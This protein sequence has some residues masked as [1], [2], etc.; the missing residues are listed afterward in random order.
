MTRLERFLEQD[1]VRYVKRDGGESLKL[2]IAGQ[3]GFPD[4]TL[5]LPGARAIF[6]ETKTLV[7]K[8]RPQQRHWLER[9]EQLGFVAQ[10]V[11]TMDEFQEIYRPSNGRSPWYNGLSPH[12]SHG[13]PP[14]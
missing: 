7:G 9:L 1:I 3:R 8:L 12:P 6:I 5:L 11:R 4:Q 14:C 13:A 2:Q 10:V